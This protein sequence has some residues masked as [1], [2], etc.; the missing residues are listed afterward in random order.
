[1]IH[2]QN[3]SVFLWWIYVFFAFLTLILMLVNPIGF[4]L[5]FYRMGMGLYQLIS[6]FW[7][8]D[9]FIYLGFFLI[10]ILGIFQSKLSLI[11]GILLLIPT[12]YFFY[13]VFFISS[14]SFSGSAVIFSRLS[15]IFAFITEVMCFALIFYNVNRCRK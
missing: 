5:Q 15:S 1:M 3:I 12:A 8:Y 2:R 6:M 10:A 13:N 14:H 9:I 4:T 7:K 11:F